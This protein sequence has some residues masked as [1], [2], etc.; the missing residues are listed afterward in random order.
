MRWT[1]YNPRPW[2]Y[3][4]QL[5][6]TCL[7]RKTRV[8][9]WCFFD[10]NILISAALISG[11]AADVA[12]RRVQEKCEPLVFS[13]ATFAELEEVLMR[14]KFNRYVAMESSRELLEVWRSSAF[15][16]PLSG[17]RVTVTDCRDAADNKFLELA[18]ASETKVIATGDPDLLVLN[19]WRKIRILTLANFLDQITL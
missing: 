9:L 1:L 10:T 17:I 7:R 2:D 18:L 8:D 16:M 13:D 12:V 14:E 19:P 5:W 11:S 15:F 4:N 6:K 3:Q